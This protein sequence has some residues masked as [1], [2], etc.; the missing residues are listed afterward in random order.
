MKRTGKCPKC[1]S[2]NIEK[3]A[4]VIDRN[5]SYSSEYEMTIATYQKPRAILFKGE[6]ISTVSAWVCADCGYLELYADAP[7]EIKVRSEES[8]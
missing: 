8:L 6:R 1:G 4:K 7:R 3:D 5:G 2:T